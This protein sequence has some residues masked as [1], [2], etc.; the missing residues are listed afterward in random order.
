MKSFN[1]IWAN[2]SHSQGKIFSTKSGNK[3]RYQIKENTITI[4]PIIPNKYI[5]ETISKSQIKSACKLIP[6][7]KYSQ[8]YHISKSPKS[9]YHIMTDP[10]I[11]QKHSTNKIRIHKKIAKTFAKYAPHFTHTSPPLYLDNTGKKISLSKIYN[12]E[13]KFAKPVTLV[14]VT[15]FQ[16]NTSKFSKYEK[17]LKSKLYTNQFYYGLSIVGRPAKIEYDVLYVTPDSKPKTIHKHL[18]MHNKL[19]SGA[20]QV[21]ALTILQ[22]GK[23]RLVRNS[24][25][26]CP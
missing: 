1:Q 7:K 18:N 8:L 21:F 9:L 16:Y 15:R 11:I 10:R 22:G 20:P 19:N 17:Y 13:S 3:F 5:K 23:F 14:A 12:T 4:L 25:H 6:I 2:I 26:Y 24:K